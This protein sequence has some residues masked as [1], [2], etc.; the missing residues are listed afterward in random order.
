MTEFLTENSIY[1]PLIIAGIIL[2]GLLFYVSRIDARLR[3]LEREEQ[4]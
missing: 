4:A 2:L 1:V 3:K